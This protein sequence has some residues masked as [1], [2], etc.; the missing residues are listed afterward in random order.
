[1]HSVLKFFVGALIGVLLLPYLVIPNKEM[2]EGSDLNSPFFNYEEVRLLEDR[3]FRDVVEEK[4]I[5][6]HNILDALINEI[7]SAETFLILD[8]FLWNEWKCKL[9]KKEDLIK[10]SESLVQAIISKRTKDPQIPILIITDPINRLYG[11]QVPEFFKRLASLGIPVVFT[12]LTA[13]PDSNWIYSKQIRFWSKFY[14]F[15]LNTNKF[16]IFPNIVESKGKRLSF[17]EFF[18]ALHLKAN[19]RKIL[20]SGYKN[21]PNRVIVGSFNPSDGSS[22]NSNLAASVSGPIADYIARSELSIVQ[23]STSNKGNLL[24]N[25]LHLEDVLRS[26][27][28]ILIKKNNF[29][30]FAL[31][32]TGVQ[33]LSEGSIG[34][35]L[36]KNLEAS[37]EGTSIDIAMFYLSDRTFVKA[38][39]AA[40]KRGANIRLLL[41][42]NK[43]AFGFK[44]MGIPNRSIADELMQL[45]EVNSIQIH[46]ASAESHAQYHTKAIRIFDKERDLVYIGSA[47][48]TKR[49]L[50]NFNLESTLVFNHVL[51]ISN[52]FDAYFDN[53]WNNEIG[54][55]ESF[56]YKALK[57]PKWMQY[58][59][60]FFYRFQEWSQISSR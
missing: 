19:H 37:G 15:S 23:W 41:D 35:S 44:K 36:I 5:L 54:Y 42:Q 55:N 48:L 45:D 46:W 17:S 14:T 3:T 1:M 2:P 40:A 34:N 28:R 52:A 30:R 47:N 8:F 4:N 9:S 50:S 25:R 7:N 53:I 13:L 32:K 16:R 22:L 43:Y 60:L 18:K 12:D 24:G 39:K 21:K 20:I 6:N 31:R 49:S 58:I 11:N 29:K 51:P 26:L 10:I 27:D 33:F 56:E 38:L 59:R 57:N